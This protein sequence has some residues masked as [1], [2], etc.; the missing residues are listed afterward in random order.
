MKDNYQIK[1]KIFLLVSGLTTLLLA[2]CSSYPSTAYDDDGIY[3][4]SNSNAVPVVVTK[5]VVVK[6]N[7]KYYEDYFSNPLTDF[8]QN[9]EILEEQEVFTD[10]DSYSSQPVSVQNN[11]VVVESYGAW[12]D[13]DD[14]VTINVYNT[15]PY[16]NSFWRPYN[17]FY[18]S[19]WGFCPPIW[20]V[21][22][23]NNG[24][25]G[26]PYV[27]YGYYG[28]PFFNNNYYGYRNIGY[29]RG[30]R[31]Y[32]YNNNYYYGRNGNYYARGRN[33][34]STNFRNNRRRNSL[35]NSK[36]SQFRRSAQG[37][38]SRPRNTSRATTK[39]SQRSTP[40][41]SPRTTPRSSNRKSLRTTPRITPR[42]SPKTSP[43]VTPRRAPRATPRSS[44]R[45]VPRFAPRS[46]RNSSRS[47]LS[48]RGR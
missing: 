9:G 26:N 18:Y 43:R 38:A 21:G 46:S 1:S 11:S 17:N 45:S 25:F 15:Q 29:A 34:N 2:S 5:N 24:Y 7:T 13:A 6:Q 41:I 19:G 8:G 35:Y 32:A 47:S 14:N 39:T 31:G 16:Y 3:G 42:T 12:E 22:Y 48:R 30:R 27:N 33:V 44:S 28:N 4:N 10:V 36:T 37:S 40:K 23:Y 20:G